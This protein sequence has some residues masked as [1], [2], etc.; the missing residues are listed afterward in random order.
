MEDEERP[1][2]LE[3]ILAAVESLL[4]EASGDPARK[5]HLEE[6]RERVATAQSRGADPGPR[7]RAPDP[8]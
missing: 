2:P 6:L 5:R 7:R 3:T 4:E 8:G 1:D